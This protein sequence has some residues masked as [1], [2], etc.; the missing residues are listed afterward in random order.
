M[1]Q[2]DVLRSRVAKKL[3]ATNPR[4][5]TASRVADA[6]RQSENSICFLLVRECDEAAEN[7]SRLA[8]AGVFNPENYNS[9]IL[10][11]IVSAFPAA[12]KLADERDEFV[13]IQLIAECVPCEL[14]DETYASLKWIIDGETEPPYREEAHI[15][16]TE[17][18]LSFFRTIVRIRR[19]EVFSRKL[20]DASVFLDTGEYDEA[21]QLSTSAVEEYNATQTPDAERHSLPCIVATYVA[22]REKQLDRVVS[23]SGIRTLDTLAGGGLFHESDLVFLGGAPGAG[24]TALA[25]QIAVNV[26]RTGKPVMFFSCEMS[27]RQIAARTMAFIS[28]QCAAGEN[29][30]TREVARALGS[31]AVP[32]SV[33]SAPGESTPEIECIAEKCR[34]VANLD[35]LLGAGMSAEDVSNRVVARVD[36]TGVAPLVVVDFLQI[37]RQSADSRRSYDKR[38][39]IEESISALKTLTMKTCA[40]VLCISSLSRGGYDKP[41]SMEHFKETGDIEYVADIEIALQKSVVFP[42]RLPNGRLE[43]KDEVSARVAA[44]EADMAVTEQ[45]CLECRDCLPASRSI[46]AKMLKNRYG[47]CGSASLEFFPNHMF[48]VDCGAFVPDKPNP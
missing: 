13:S 12:C 18:I 9:Q 14:R 28:A 21:A 44:Y 2:S 29:R 38:S 45:Y 23:A 39:V 24:K 8:H 11:T 5:E 7:V 33:L 22:A 15:L 17:S 10:R 32:V 25:T 16:A 30:D 1:R 6:I 27:L 43:S 35:V 26:A 47:T 34:E 46:V 20:H 40:S 37:L 3:P 31:A 19:E 42:R 41:I 36:R 48:F 4:E